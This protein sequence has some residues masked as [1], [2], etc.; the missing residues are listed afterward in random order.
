MRLILTTIIFLTAFNSNAQ[1]D[2]AT[3][4][5]AGA[6]ITATSYLIL[7]TTEMSEV[8][9]LFLS[10]GIGTFAGLSKEIFDQARGGEFDIEDFGFT[11]L[12]SIHIGAA[13]GNNI[14]GKR[15]K[16]LKL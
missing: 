10:M 3:H 4:Y 15:K 14:N 1:L 2:K 7:E 8:K 9:C 11:L 16:A 13:I 5:F 6:T 12:G